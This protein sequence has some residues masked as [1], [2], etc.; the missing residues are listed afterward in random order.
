MKKFIILFIFVH[1]FNL[2]SQKFHSTIEKDIFESYKKDSINYNF[3]KSICAIDSTL[4]KDNLSDYLSQI[5][6]TISKISPKETKEKKE[7]K[8]V[9][10]IY[11]TF[12]KRFLKKYELESY[13]TD[14]FKSGTYN[15]VTASAL[16][17]YVFDRLQIPYH[18]KEVPSHVY[19]IAYPDTFK[20]YLET[21]V[22]GAYGFSSPK[23]SE[24]KK[25][26]DELI[27]IKLIAKSELNNKGY[28]DTYNDYF[29]GK[30]FVKTA[31]LI[32]MQYY[33][34]SIFYFQEEDYLNAENNLS[35]SLVFYNSPLAKLLY[36][37]L[38]KLNIN[39]LQFN[40]MEDITVL[41]KY[42]SL[43]EYKKDYKKI[44]LQYFLYKIIEND[45]ND[46][47]FIKKAGKSFNSIDNI[48]LKNLCKET[49]YNYIT[50]AEAD[51]YN[52]ESSLQ[53]SDSIL[54]INKNSKI[55]KE[56]I[57]YVL[58]KKIS[59]KGSN[60]ASLLEVEKYYNKHSFL[61]NDKRIETIRGLL[62]GEMTIKEVINKN[63]E[64]ALTYLTK[65]EE[66]IETKKEYLMLRSEFYP[67]VYLK[68]GRYFYGKNKFKK[69]K[70]IFERGLKTSPDNPDLKK[71]YRWAK[72][73]M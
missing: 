70:D 57:P 49:I 29:Y 55:A 20:I 54:A 11:D 42:L 68:A 30:E 32:G 5:E 34:K 28:T 65:F 52:F 31:S 4:S 53:Y 2:F 43:L 17:A 64:K 51:K 62:Y 44:E 16:Y 46:L 6:T 10:S 58:Q 50:K 21:T 8:R 15:C 36:K 3:I 24:I 56:V 25:I 12:H 23:E 38:I 60:E 72:E 39:N 37:D 27:N 18:V 35:K 40:K 59:I 7:I 71:M 48:E 41:Q 69:A 33:N 61:K 66:V 47:N 9:K 19:L 13:F 73:D 1:S 45:N 26:V 67:F 63:I 22:P 14:I